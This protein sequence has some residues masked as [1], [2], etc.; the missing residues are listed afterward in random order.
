MGRKGMTLE[1]FNDFMKRCE[2]ITQV[3]YVKPTIHSKFKQIVAISIV[4][5]SGT[6]E[7]SVTNHPDEQFDLNRAANQWLDAQQGENAMNKQVTSET[8]DALIGEWHE[9]DSPEDLH[10]FLGLT[11]EEYAQWVKTNEL[12]K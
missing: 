10:E 5:S 1:Q 2:E 12:P 6:K 3:S 7:L 4:T 11:L 9:G 8:I